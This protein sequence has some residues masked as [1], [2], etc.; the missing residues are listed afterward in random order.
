MPA[1]LF[2]RARPLLTF[3]AGPATRIPQAPPQDRHDGKQSAQGHYQPAYGTASCGDMR[4]VDTGTGKA[5]VQL[6]HR[7]AR[8]IRLSSAVDYK[9]VRNR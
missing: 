2:H 9:R 8:E 1:R 3:A 5:S 4:F 6:N 7:S